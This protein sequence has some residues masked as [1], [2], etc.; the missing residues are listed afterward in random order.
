VQ[1]GGDLEVPYFGRFIIIDH[2]YECLEDNK[3]RKEE[4]VCYKNPACRDEMSN[5]KVDRA[6][7]GVELEGREGMNCFILFRANCL[8]RQ[9]YCPIKAMGINSYE[10]SVTNIHSQQT[11]L[12]VGSFAY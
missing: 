3:R 9:G 10:S 6:I 7:R 5:S 8:Q 1:L 2:A 12:F 4:P 11:D